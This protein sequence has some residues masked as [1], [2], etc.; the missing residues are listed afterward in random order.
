MISQAPGRPGKIDH[1]LVEEAML[2]IVGQCKGRNVAVGVFTDAI[3]S[4]R[5]SIAHCVDVGI[6]S[7]TVKTFANDM[8][9]ED[10]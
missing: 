2:E 4:T 8:K 10:K 6:F 3:V 9:T 7:D 5:K 1:L